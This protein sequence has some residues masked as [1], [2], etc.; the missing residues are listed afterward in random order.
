MSEHTT[1]EFIARGRHSW[2]QMAV[3]QCIKVDSTEC[4]LAR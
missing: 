2:L 4:L 3:T 1:E